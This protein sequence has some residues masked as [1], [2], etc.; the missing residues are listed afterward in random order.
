MGSEAI[1]LEN[2]TEINNME[3]DLDKD[4]TEHNVSASSLVSRTSSVIIKPLMEVGMMPILFMLYVMEILRKWATNV[5]IGKSN[6]HNILTD[7][8][9]IQRCTEDE[10]DQVVK[11]QKQIQ[12]D[13]D[14]LQERLN[15]IEQRRKQRQSVSSQGM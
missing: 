2:K 15:N 6:D 3:K 14:N 5:H 13:M 8:K 7:T 9:Q 11:D 10:I 1:I 4:K 12:E